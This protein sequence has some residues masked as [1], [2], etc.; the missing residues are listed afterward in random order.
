MLVC[1]RFQR[2]GLSWEFRIR[3]FTWSRWIMAGPHGSFS[4]QVVE[5]LMIDEMETGAVLLGLFQD[6]S[7]PKTRKMFQK[8]HQK[9]YIQTPKPQEVWMDVYGK[10]YFG[11]FSFVVCCFL[12]MYSAII[13]H[14][15]RELF[16]REFPPTINYY[17][18]SSGMSSLGVCGLSR[19]HGNFSAPTSQKMEAG[20]C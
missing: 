12:L 3:Q 10:T 13:C 5:T 18:Q 1:Q 16:K 20:L 4:K 2:L 11:V 14:N 7:I 19:Y 17:A 8:K 6:Q 15:H 9:M